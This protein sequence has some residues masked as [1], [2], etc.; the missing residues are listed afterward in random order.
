MKLFRAVVLSLSLLAAATFGFSADSPEKTAV[1]GVIIDVR[2]T[3]EFEEGHLE[4]A[5]NLPYDKIGETIQ[6]AVP[7]RN[8]KIILYCRTGRRSGIA[9]ET[10]KA[11]GYE[12]VT[13]L[14]TVK[15][16]SEKLGVPI[17]KGNK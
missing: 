16:A 15:E 4:G 3:P 11:L 13:N 2:T 10:L 8:S 6:A 9:L 5:L 7:N 1:K 14:K 17:I 12:D